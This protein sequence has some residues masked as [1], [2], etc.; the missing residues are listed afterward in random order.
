[1][2]GKRIC[3]GRKASR[4]GVS[5]VVGMTI[6][7]LLFT[8]A[9]AYVFIWTQSSGLY[10]DSV[11]KQVDFERSRLSEKL[12]VTALNNTNVLVENPTAEVIVVT[13]VW[14][15]HNMTFEGSKGISPFGSLIIPNNTGWLGGD[16]NFTVVTSRGNIFSAKFQSPLG[17][18]VT[19]HWNG[20][21]SRATYDNP[22]LMPP[23]AT[24]TNLKIGTTNWNDLNLNYEWSYLNNPVIA[25]TY[26]MT[27]D[28]DSGT[29]TMLG[30]VAKVT[31]IKLTDNNSDA[32]INFY[33][34][35]NSRIAIS[36]WK[37]GMNET[38]PSAWVNQSQPVQITGDLYQKYVVAIYFYGFGQDYAQ[39]R[40]NVVNA[41][42][43]R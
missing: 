10:I 27:E 11:K 32:W 19:W 26:T 7:L 21:V 4:K 29:G 1:M 22:I 28:K 36:L 17:W 37:V 16:G 5:T 31:L 33:N 23:N 42:F 20:N 41:T 18:E 40:L 25:G 6:F 35:T 39:V 9:V 34:S 14:S 3:R 30:F 15:A 43:A 38:V 8:I 24:L 12:I 13:Q 2:P